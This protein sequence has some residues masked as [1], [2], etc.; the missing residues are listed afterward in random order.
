[1][2][3]RENEGENGTEEKRKTVLEK[4]NGK[5]KTQER[6]E[7]RTLDNEKK[8]VGKDGGWERKELQMERKE[9]KNSNRERK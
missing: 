7:I 3:L 4:E 9:G 6:L 2:R 1:M 5:S 8:V